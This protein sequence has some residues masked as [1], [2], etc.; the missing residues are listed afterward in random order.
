MPLATDA[1]CC[2]AATDAASFSCF[3]DS[4]LYF[5]SLTSGSPSSSST[6]PSS[7][8]SFASCLETALNLASAWAS[9]WGGGAA[10]WGAAGVAVFLLSLINA[11]AAHNFSRQP[12]TSCDVATHHTGSKHARANGVTQ[13]VSGSCSWHAEACFGRASAACC[14]RMLVSVHARVD[15]SARE[16]DSGRSHPG[17]GRVHAQG[18]GAGTGRRGR[19]QGQGTGKGLCLRPVIPAHHLVVRVK[20]HLTRCYP[21]SYTQDTALCCRRLPTTWY[22]QVPA[23]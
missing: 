23:Q 18:Q 4:C 12:D 16:F 1:C 17:R 19:V 10:C 15:C 21:A 9:V 2:S 13:P 7:L 14:L 5:F 6:K 22:E 20:W 8:F 3:L 11:R